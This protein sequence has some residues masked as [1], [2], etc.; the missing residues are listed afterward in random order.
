M[1]E[2][3]FSVTPWR[4]LVQSMHGDL[5]GFSVLLHAPRRRSQVH[6]TNSSTREASI[7]SAGIGVKMPSRPAPSSF[8]SGVNFSVK[9]ESVFST[10]LAFRWNRRSV[11]L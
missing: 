1:K 10:E 11:I 2:D 9:L 7:V 3:R 4:R 5:S 8:S 6:F